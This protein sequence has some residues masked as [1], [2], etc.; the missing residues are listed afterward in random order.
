GRRGSGRDPRGD[1]PRLGLR[2]ARGGAAGGLRHRLR[3]DVACAWA[4]LRPRLRGAGPR[5]GGPVAAGR[6]G[7][8]RRDRPR[9][10]CH[11]GRG[12]GGA[13]PGRTPP[14]LRPPVLGGARP[15]APPPPPAPETPPRPATAPGRREGGS[16]AR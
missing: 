12:S 7:G 4:R 5:G 14:P 13:P 3:A 9:R 16:G 10:P 11:E 8:G 15:P 1:R 2:D 6:Q